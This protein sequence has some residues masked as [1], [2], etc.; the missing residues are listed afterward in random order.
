MDIESQF[1]QALQAADN[2]TIVGDM[3]VLNKA[4]MAPLA[5]FKTVYMK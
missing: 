5:R 2:Y 3:L 4:P 1:L